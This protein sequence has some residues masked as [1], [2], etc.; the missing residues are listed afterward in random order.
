MERP[1]RGI[2]G[3]FWILLILFQPL[4]SFG[5]ELKTR[6]ATVQYAD[7]KLLYEF[8]EEL[9]VGRQL[10]RML[11]GMRSVSR[12]DDIKNKIDLVVEKVEMVLDMFPERIH[13]TL[14]LL[15]SRKDV[16][17]IYREK[18]S[19]KVDHI[20]YYSLKEKTIYIA[21]DDASLRVFSHEIGH[22]IVDHYFEVRP[23]YRIHEVLAQYAEEHVTD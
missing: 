7:T 15:P 18:Y 23:P 11:K 8:D 4:T 20:A 5:Q 17:R 19:K 6:Y 22:M 13:F 9:Y 14:V 10:G 2:W 3:I 12:Q 1:P 16:Q 21:V